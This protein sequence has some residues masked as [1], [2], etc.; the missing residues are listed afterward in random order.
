MKMKNKG[1]KIIASFLFMILCQSCGSFS[2]TGT[3]LSQDLKTITIQNFVMATAG[4]P[5]NMS[6]TLNEKL[7]EYY[8]RNTNLKLK[9]AEGDL[10]L[11]GAIVSYDLSPVSAT[12][13]D[14]AALNRLTITVEVRFENKLDENQG[15]ER[16][17]SF[18]QDFSAEKSLTEVEATLVPKIL[19]QLVLDI[20]TNTAAQW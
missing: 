4:G 6:I 19:D 12:S 3:T 2:F 7:K 1:M 16:D 13:S 20:F 9:Q 5:Q 8:Q 15:F 11:E 14:K 17:F 18:Y 10:R